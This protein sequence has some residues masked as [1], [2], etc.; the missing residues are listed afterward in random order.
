[1]RDLLASLSGTIKVA[2]EWMFEKIESV[3]VKTK[4]LEVE[5]G[6][7][8]KDKASGEYYCLTLQN[9]EFVKEKGD[10]TSQNTGGGSVS[11]DST[12]SASSTSEVVKSDS[13]NTS[14]SP[15]V[16][17]ADLSPESADS[18]TQSLEDS[19]SS[20]GGPDTIP[21]PQADDVPTEETR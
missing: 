18:A 20:A 10:C 14:S 21:P 6:I 12:V 11:D 15:V 16:T 13:M 17:E 19:S 2:G 3:F 9:G 8:L 1:M 4:L 5:E 7:I